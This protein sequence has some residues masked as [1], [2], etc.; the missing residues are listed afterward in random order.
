ME[1]VI[2]VGMVM[3][4]CVAVAVLAMAKQ[5]S[6]ENRK[7]RMEERVKMDEMNQRLLSMDAGSG[8]G[9]E[10]TQE[11]KALRED[12][13]ALSKQVTE[14]KEQIQLRGSSFPSAEGIVSPRT[15][16]G[17]ERLR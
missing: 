15:S 3:F 12:V 7:L 16:T 9:L 1:D 17:E 6:V 2:V 8:A 14:L 11:L 4:T 10:V 5:W 13:K